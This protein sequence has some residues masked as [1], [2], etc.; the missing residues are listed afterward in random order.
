MAI[1]IDGMGYVDDWGMDDSWAYNFDND[2]STVF[3]P[4]Y[5][6]LDFDYGGGLYDLPT[7]NVPEFNF[8][9]ATSPLSL[10][11][12]WM[13]DFVD[14]EFNEDG[15][16]NWDNFWSDFGLEDPEVAGTYKG[17]GTM[18][19]KEEGPLG[20]LNE[21]AKKILGAGQ[22]ASRSTLG[23]ILKAV[24]TVA[25]TKK[26]GENA[27]KAATSARNYAEGKADNFGASTGRFKSIGRDRSD[28]SSM[29]ANPRFKKGGNIPGDISTC[30]MSREDLIRLITG[31]GG[32]QS[33]KITINASPGEY[34]M[35]ADVVSALGDGDT[36][37]GARRLD[38]MRENVRKHKRSANHKSIPPK[39]KKPED[40]MG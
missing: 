14:G 13:P 17:T 29:L 28:P 32:G 18:I 10:E 35:D 20:K 36:N 19:G 39:S 23:Q 5:W 11:E 15:S 27:R 38:E 34:I 33:D 22:D 31:Q 2:Y 8:E 3:D 37:E 30:D 12:G 1:Y 25:S 4:D 40:Y 21:L 26:T 6:N 7:F 16:F 24:A 9:L